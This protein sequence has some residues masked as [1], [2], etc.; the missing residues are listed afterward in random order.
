MQAVEL[1]TGQ[2]LPAVSEEEIQDAAQDGK[3]AG[4]VEN[5][6]AKQMEAEAIVSPAETRKGTAAKAFQRVK[7]D[8]WM[9]SK[10][11][12]NNSYEATFGNQGWGAKAQEVLG[13]VL[14]SL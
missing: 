5:E 11:A 7:A 8:E 6:L 14:I 12:R 1:F 4:M 3:A 13:Q 2:A 10:A 9:H